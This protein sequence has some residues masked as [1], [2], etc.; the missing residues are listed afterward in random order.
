MDH[1]EQHH[2]KH[3]KD[4]EHEQ[5]EHKEHERQQEK[6]GLLPFHPAW[7]FAIGAVL[8]LAAVLVWTFL[9]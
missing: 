3:E 6:K 9:L 8:A 2:Q 4:R 7:L 1:K 5:R